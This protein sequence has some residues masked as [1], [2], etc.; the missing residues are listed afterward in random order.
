MKRV[1]PWQAVKLRAHSGGRGVIWLPDCGNSRTKICEWLLHDGRTSALLLAQPLLAQ[2]WT[3][4][5]NRVDRLRCL[6]LANRRLKRF[7]GTPNTAQF[8]GRV[9]RWEQGRARYSLT[10]VD[11]SDAERI[12]SELGHIAYQGGPGAGRSTSCRRVDAAAARWEAG[13]LVAYDAW[14]Y[15]ERVTGHELRLTNSDSRRSS[16]DLSTR[17]SPVHS[18]RNRGQRRGAAHHLPA[19]VR[20]PGCRREARPVRDF[21]FN[22]L[23]PPRLKR[24]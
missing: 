14:H 11:Y 10:V 12:H 17:E 18:R 7:P 8:P 5:E 1:A 6:H 21:Y 19:V 16:L 2:G 20:F 9:Y 13:R 24:P 23:P 22:R 3:E 15:I 4:C